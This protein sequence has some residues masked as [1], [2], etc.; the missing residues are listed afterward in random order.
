MSTALGSERRRAS[1]SAVK[2]PQRS[3]VAALVFFAFTAP[4]GIAAH[5][6][7]ELAGLGWHDDA[8][9]IFSSRHAY[10][11]LIAVGSVSGLFLALRALRRG[12]RRARIAA[13]IDVLPCK[14]Q[15]VGFTAVS[16]VAQFAFF[17][18]TQVGEGCPL[19]SGD[20]FVGAVA[21]TLA[22]FLGAMLV[23][24]GKRRMLELAI[25]LGCYLAVILSTSGATPHSMRERRAA[26][27]PTRRRTPFA[28]RYRPPPLNAAS[29]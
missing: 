2:T 8:D 17:A 15:G 23:A 18:L 9:V 13:L 20:V 27:A 11:A 4:F 16:F 21:A 5:L 7:S 25:A 12:D 1:R 26:M 22:A 6:I 14:G 24:L 29:P 10:L 19:C 28:F 3:F